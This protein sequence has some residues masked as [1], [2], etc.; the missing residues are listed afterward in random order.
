MW[1]YVVNL[2]APLWES[3]V[4]VCTPPRAADGAAAP[5]GTPLAVCELDLRARPTDFHAGRLISHRRVQTCE[6]GLFLFIGR[7]R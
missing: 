5:K 2:R 4:V 6:L 3:F 1:A 7:H